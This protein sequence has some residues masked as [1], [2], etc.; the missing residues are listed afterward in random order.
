[1]GNFADIIEQGIVEIFTLFDHQ[2]TVLNTLQEGNIFGELALIDGRPRSASAI[3]K[4]D[5][6][7]CVIHQD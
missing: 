7:L 1:M 3:A 2:K 5:V 4:T 6:I